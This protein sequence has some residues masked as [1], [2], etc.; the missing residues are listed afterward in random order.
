MVNSLKSRIWAI[1]A[2]LAVVLTV[3]CAGIQL[4]SHM[5]SI[6]VFKARVGKLAAWILRGDLESAINKAPAAGN[7]KTALSESLSSLYQSGTI[8]SVKI[9]SMDGRLIAATPDIAVDKES[10]LSPLDLFNFKKVMPK[11]RASDPNFSLV[12]DKKTKTLHVYIPLA[13]AGPL[14][15]IARQDTVLGTLKEALRQGYIFIFLS[16]ITILLG[17]L[18]F[19]LVLAHSIISPI[20][21]LSQ[22]ARNMAAGDLDL[23]IRVD[24]NDDLRMLADSLNTMAIQLKKKAR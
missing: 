1:M 6:T 21:M 10:G 2:M 4:Q 11:D 17:C 12:I 3:S 24:T 18:L 8:E 23:H 19:G 15:Y 5:R 20:S 22:T 16:S 9:Y 7:R 14:T 13:V